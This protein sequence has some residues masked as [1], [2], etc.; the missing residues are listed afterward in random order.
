MHCTVK[1]TSMLK[2]AHHPPKVFYTN[3]KKRLKRTSK[4]ELTASVSGEKKRKKKKKERKANALKRF[5]ENVFCFVFVFD[6]TI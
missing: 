6:E 4:R 1:V 3:L 2:G 5:K